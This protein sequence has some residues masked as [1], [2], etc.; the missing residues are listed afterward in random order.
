MV[1]VVAMAIIFAGPGRTRISVQTA[2]FLHVIW[3]M[4]A[5]AEQDS[6]VAFQ[7]NKFDCSDAGMVYWWITGANKG[8]NKLST[9]KNM[10]DMLLM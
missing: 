7:S 6:V 9:P 4:M 5:Y 8:G 3:E 2:D 1:A 10:K